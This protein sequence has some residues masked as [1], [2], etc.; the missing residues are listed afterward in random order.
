MQE[1]NI[2]FVIPLIREHWLELGV[3]AREEPSFRWSEEEPDV[4]HVD[5]TSDEA[6]GLWSLFVTDDAY[7]PEQ[8]EL[9]QFFYN[10][11]RPYGHLLAPPNVVPP[12]FTPEEEEEMD[13]TREEWARERWHYLMV[14]S[15]LHYE[16]GHV[17]PEVS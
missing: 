16:R 7:G 2:D 17:S 14:R 1:R 10:D 13:I 4:V 5:L 8:R 6:P 3:N 15:G 9:A 11:G 12:V